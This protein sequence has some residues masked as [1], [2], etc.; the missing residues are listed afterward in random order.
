MTPAN[1]QLEN[2]V[3][4]DAIKL[5]EAI[6]KDMTCE[7]NSILENYG[8]GGIAE[9]PPVREKVIELADGK[10]VEYSELNEIDDLKWYLKEILRVINEFNEPNSSV[11]RRLWLCEN[12]LSHIEI[13]AEEALGIE[14]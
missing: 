8:K 12:V 10:D 4:E 2:M 14:D 11:E 13:M 5:R 9:E 1:E 6:T 3:K 7:I